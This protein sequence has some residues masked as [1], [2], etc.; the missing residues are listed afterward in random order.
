MV[1]FTVQRSSVQTVRV[2]GAP[3]SVE[4]WRTQMP[5][6]LPRDQVGVVSG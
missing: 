3:C 5:A 1:L 2:G 4:P 6:S